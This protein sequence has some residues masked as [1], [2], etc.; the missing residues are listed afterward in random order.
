MLVT[1]TKKIVVILSIGI[2]VACVIVIGLYFMI[3]RTSQKLSKL[4]T[5]I[6]N[7][8]A[9]IKADES[10]RDLVEESG[11]DIDTL[12]KRI[13]P[14]NGTVNF[15]EIIESFARNNGITVAIDTV[16]E[17]ELNPLSETYESL[18]L[19]FS[20]EGSWRST[21]HFIELIESLPY[22]VTINQLG[23][24][25]TGESASSSARWSGAYNIEVLKYK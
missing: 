23:I 25:G 6:Q 8:N 3:Q 16:K 21:H 20:T 7:K 15:I 17:I 9:Q 2:I 14:S 19:I 13:I 10:L 1:R 11:D 5:D 24:T 18:E 22:K 4:E 12:M